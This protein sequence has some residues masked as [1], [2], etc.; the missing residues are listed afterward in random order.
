MSYGYAVRRRAY[1][2]PKRPIG[3][4]II[5]AIGMLFGLALTLVAL[6]YAWF[7]M[8]ATGSMAALT[9]DL[10]V[11]LGVSLFVLWLFWGLWDL[12]D[13]AWWTNMIIDT[14]SVF[15]SIYTLIAAPS[16]TMEIVPRI[17][18]EIEPIVFYNGLIAGSIISLALTVIMM[19][20]LLIVRE[21][22]GIGTKHLLK[23]WE[24]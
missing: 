20:Y 1:T 10:I 22:F 11:G 7:H 21:A 23:P 5:A 18:F 3:I 8:Q 2:P 15:G 16:L 4:A 17:P 12:M 24:R 19:I 9:A 14:V 13:W 6:V